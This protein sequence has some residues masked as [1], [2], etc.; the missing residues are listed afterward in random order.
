MINQE[1]LIEVSGVKL[2]YDEQSDGSEYGTYYWTEFHTQ[3]GTIPEKKWSWRKFR[4]VPTGRQIP[5]YVKRFRF[6]FW[7]TQ[8]NHM[9]KSELRDMLERQVELINRAKELENKEFI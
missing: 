6:N 1:N 9:T 5:N 2:Y 3:E 8:S 4:M 7:I